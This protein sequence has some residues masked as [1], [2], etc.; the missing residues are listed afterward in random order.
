VL[1]SLDLD[2]RCDLWQC[3]PVLSPAEFADLRQ[4]LALNC[5]KWDAQV[6]DVSTLAP[7]ALI[8]PPQTWQQLATLAEQLSAE[9]IAAETELLQRP[10]LIQHLGLPRSVRLALLAQAPVQKAMPPA[11][12]VCRYDFHPTPQGWR[13]SEANNDVPGGYTEASNFC[14]MLAAHLPGTQPAGN[15]AA[16]LVE[17]LVAQMGG[18]GAIALISAPGYLEDQQITAY[19]AELLHQRGCQAYLA[20]PQQIYWPESGEA[21][22]A[23]LRSQWYHGP[24]A[25]VLRFYQGEWMTRLPTD[26]DWSYFF[27]GSRTPICNPGTALLIESKRF[28][29]VWS[30]LK[31]PLPTWQALLPETRSPYPIHWL[32]DPSW[33]LKSAFCNTGD[34]VAMRGLSDRRQYWRTVGQALLRPDQW[35]VQRR[36]ETVGIPTPEGVMYPCLGVY[37]VNGQ[38]AGIYGRMA[39]QPLINFAAIDV[40][41]LIQDEHGREQH[42]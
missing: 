6:G 39:R 17:A 5:F 15:P 32:S 31:T 34:T 28:P 38:A 12:R 10:E 29:L 23:Y 25:A 30:A 36:F 37:T 13:I 9:A 27:G 4:Q 41:V 18:T 40:A 16:Q 22:Q 11:A 35:I 26:Y 24:L 21:P 7:F 19:L 42:G 20:S 14:Q 1:D 3:S 8:L 33:L 2:C